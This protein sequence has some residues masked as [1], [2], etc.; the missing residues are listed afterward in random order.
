MIEYQV[1]RL[2]T[3]RG[4]E[5]EIVCVRKFCVVEGRVRKGSQELEGLASLLECPCYINLRALPIGCMVV[6]RVFIDCRGGCPQAS[7]GFVIL[8][9]EGR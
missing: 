9:A 8:G 4:P 6:T 5:G 7:G 2:S 1:S 3:R